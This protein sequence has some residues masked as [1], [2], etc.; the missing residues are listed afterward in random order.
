M[1]D[2]YRASL[3]RT[4]LKPATLLCL[5]MVVAA[6]WFAPAAS[7]VAVEPAPLERSG[8]SCPTGYRRSGEYCVP[9]K[10][11]S[12]AAMPRAGNSCPTGYRRSGEYCVANTAEA[13][14]VIERSGSSC[15]TGYR[16]SGDYCVEN[17]R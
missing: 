17:A 2:L 4:R 9:Y 12:R 16:R 1:L 5:G 15:P 8:S 6:A 10:D 7:V 3:V 13:A 14:R 11:T